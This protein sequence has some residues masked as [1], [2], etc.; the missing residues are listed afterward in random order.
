MFMKK[1]FATLSCLSFF[2]V[3]GVVG[4][5][6]CETMDF[7]EGIVCMVIGILCGFLFVF[8]AGVCENMEEK[9][10]HRK[11]QFPQ[12]QAKSSVTLYTD[13]GGKSSHA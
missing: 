8:L 4:G 3:Y 13:I 10:R 2:Y 7:R 1:L 9:S 12:R 11:K 6:E 5:I